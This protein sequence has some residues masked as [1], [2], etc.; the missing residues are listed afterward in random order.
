MRTVPR[1]YWP[2]VCDVTELG[3]GHGVIDSLSDTGSDSP[4]HIH[5]SLTVL[6]SMSLMPATQ[7]QEL[8]NVEMV[9]RTDERTS[10]EEPG[11]QG[12]WR[13]S[14]GPDTTEEVPNS[15]HQALHSRK[16]DHTA[17]FCGSC[18]YHR[19]PAARLAGFRP[20]TVQFAGGATQQQQQQHTLK[21]LVSET[22]TRNLLEK[23]DASS[24]QFLAPKPKQLSSQSRCIVRAGQFLCWNRAVLKCVQE[25]CTRK[26]L[27]PDW[28]THVQWCKFLSCTRWLAQVPG[29]S[30]LGMCCRHNINN[31]IP[32]CCCWYYY[33][34]WL[35]GKV[36]AVKVVAI[37]QKITL[38]SY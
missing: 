32:H 15:P 16:S 30:F 6:P 22:C 29:T 35:I 36:F 33:S 20:T 17:G 23:F 8:V 19:F 2:R 3:D 26:K 24:S 11:L 13:T 21:K 25:N 27:L 37:D 9:S 5:R 7:A 4:W 18:G 12:A 28:P 31:N 34:F 14:R 10:L 1:R 38:V